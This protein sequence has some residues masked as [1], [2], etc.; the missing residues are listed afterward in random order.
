MKTPYWTKVVEKAHIRKA[1]GKP[2]FTWHQ[3]ELSGDFVTCACGK[4][5][6]RLL[7]GAC[8]APMDNVLYSLG[9]KFNR[10]VCGFDPVAAAET[11]A[12][13]EFRSGEL[14]AKMEEI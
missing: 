6:P 14:L 11:L 1:A 2:A 10:N 7:H 9:L 12:L 3:R 4:Q 8:R 5:D 13:I